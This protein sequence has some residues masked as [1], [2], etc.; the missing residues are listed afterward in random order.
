MTLPD[1]TQQFLPNFCDV[2]ILFSM[3]ILAELLAFTL[4]LA[5]PVTHDQITWWSQLSLV[6]LF[7]QWVV[8]ASALS[9]CIGRRW[10]NTLTN[11]QA[12]VVAYVLLLVITG[13]VSEI[14]YRIIQIKS[15]STHLEFIFR[16]LTVSGII[17]ALTLRYFYVQYRMKQTV[18]SET[19][20]RIQALQARIRPHF[21]FNSMNTIASLT[22]TQPALAEEVVV[23]LAE[24]FRMTLTDTR[25]K[26]TLKE[27]L[28]L[29]QRYLHIEKLRLGERLKVTW[30]MQNLTDD[31]PLPALIIQPLLENAIY[32][33]IE[34]LPEGGAVH[35]TGWQ[36]NSEINITINN[37]IP[38][39]HTPHQRAGHGMALE[40]IRERLTMHYGEQGELL[41]ERNDTEY[42]VR[43]TFPALHTDVAVLAHPSA[44]RTWASFP[45][46]VPPEAECRQRPSRKES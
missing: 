6:S 7:I 8:L 13:L 11:R 40:N 19:R 34:P 2:R 28:D 10:L 30:N 21:L 3:V 39:Q 4:T 41:L 23:D 45:G 46:Q 44:H 42:Q 22:R 9:L 20:A 29:C 32:H 38:P 35:I 26:I 33:G 14:A 16:N 5:N 15:H 27:E 36:D 1:T 17:S 31:T 12:A 43:I 25:E 24:L 37:P 18:E